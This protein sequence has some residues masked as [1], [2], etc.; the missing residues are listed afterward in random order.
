[1]L[2]D[3]SLMITHKQRIYLNI[4]V[5]HR[6]MVASQKENIQQKMDAQLAMGA[7]DLLEADRAFFNLGH[8]DLNMS[9]VEDHQYWLHAMKAARIAPWTTRDNNCTKPRVD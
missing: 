3:I 9:N 5:H 6:H 1:M 7:H 8:P 2:F 4:V